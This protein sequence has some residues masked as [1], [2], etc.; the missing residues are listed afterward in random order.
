MPFLAH[1]AHGRRRVRGEHRLLVALVLVLVLLLLLLL[2]G[3]HRVGRQQA[4][5][6]VR[7]VAAAAGTAHPVARAAIPRVVS[8]ALTALSAVAVAGMSD[9]AATDFPLPI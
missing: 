2:H 5:P 6:A 8:P 3:Q 9:F 1:V 7:G 4:L